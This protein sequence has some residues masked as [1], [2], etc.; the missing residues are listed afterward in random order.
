M[1]K[2][3]LLVT[4]PIAPPWDEASKNFAF[5]LA[6][7]LPDFEFGLLTNGA[8]EN[9]SMNIKQ[10][11]IYSSNKNN[12]AQ[13]LR[14]IINLRK[15]AR[16][17]DI[18]HCLFTPTKLNSHLLKT[19]LR[20]KRVIQTIATL[21][22]DLFCDCEI[23]KLM[24]GNLLVTY[25]DYSKNKLAGLGFGNVEKVYPGIDLEEY[26]R[27][28]K[29]HELLSRYGFNENDFIINFTGEYSRLGAIDD[30]VDSFIEISKKI[31]NAKLSLAVRIK[32][33]KD[34]V[35]KSLILEKL[36]S[37]GLLDKTAFHDDATYRMSDVYNVCDISLF[38]VREM[39]GKFDVPLAV[40]EAMACEKPVIISDLPILREF[41]NNKNSVIIKGG[42]RKELADAIIKFY[43]DKNF[44]ESIGKNARKF[45]EEN[46]N[47]KKV[48]SQYKDIYNI[49]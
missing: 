20:G 2:K 42:N 31:E 45:V 5:N 4:R 36:K 49:L 7:N 46:F 15:I 32:N 47:I 1:L 30:V 11:P 19:L 33:E 9:L 22:E 38:P 12:F 3:I 35:K 16:D 40:I 48:A 44:R 8:L 39:K 25:S 10:H 43:E 17:Y 26:I 41:S 34:A 29:N 18:I 21:R 13:K 6:A 23:K 27:R 24:F 37:A 28:E 14:L